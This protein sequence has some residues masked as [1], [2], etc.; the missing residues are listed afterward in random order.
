MLRF[1]HM[2]VSMQK[3]KMSGIPRLR[4]ITSKTRAMAASEAVR[5]VSIS[6]LAT[7]LMS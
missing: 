6:W 1:I 2:E 5:T 3:S 7:C 4:N